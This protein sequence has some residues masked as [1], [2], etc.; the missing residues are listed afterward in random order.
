MPA[1][2]GKDDEESNFEKHFATLSIQT[3]SDPNISALQ[4]IVI[5]LYYGATW[6]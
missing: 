6:A 4:T 3:A 5:T 1:G 2:G